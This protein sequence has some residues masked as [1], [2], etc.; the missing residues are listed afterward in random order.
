MR[1][2][3]GGVKGMGEQEVIHISGFEG[4]ETK[5]FRD[6]R[7]IPAEPINKHPKLVERCVEEVAHV[8]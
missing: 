2:D 3:S 8:F 5:L 7:G 6:L 1:Q 4:L